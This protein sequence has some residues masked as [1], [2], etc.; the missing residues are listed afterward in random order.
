ME[1]RYLLA[2]N[3]STLMRLTLSVTF[4]LA[5]GAEPS[6]HVA[7][8]YALRRCQ[9]AICAVGFCFSARLTA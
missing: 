9:T 1:S 6:R 5:L 4:R 3:A 8:L 2:K 7:V